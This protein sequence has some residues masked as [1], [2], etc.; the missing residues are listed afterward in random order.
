MSSH[1]NA[2]LDTELRRCTQQLLEEA[3]KHQTDADSGSA[4]QSLCP[5]SALA[6][7]KTVKTNA[8]GCV[9]LPLQGLSALRDLGFTPATGN[10]FFYGFPKDEGRCKHMGVFPLQRMLYSE[11]MA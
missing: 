1:L 10:G 8:A 6:Q 2:G 9:W 5:K 7:R 11:L 3:Q 4:A